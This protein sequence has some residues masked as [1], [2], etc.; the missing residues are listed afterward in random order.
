MIASE[1]GSIAA[2]VFR[3]DVPP[4]WREIPPIVLFKSGFF[5]RAQ[6]GVERLARD[7]SFDRAVVYAVWDDPAQ[8]YLSAGR[9]V[10]PGV[11]AAML[12]PSTLG[13]G[14]PWIPVQAA[15]QSSQVELET[16]IL[17]PWLDQVSCARFR[18]QIAVGKGKLT[19][20]TDPS[21]PVVADDGPLADT[22]AWLAAHPDDT[23]VGARVARTMLVDCGH[24]LQRYGLSLMH[25]PDGERRAAIE[26]ILTPLAPEVGA[27]LGALWEMWERP[28]AQRAATGPT[29]ATIEVA[30]VLSRNLQAD[31]PLQQASSMAVLVTWLAGLFGIRTERTGR[32]PARTLFA[33]ARALRRSGRHLDA[34]SHPDTPLPRFPLDRAEADAVVRELSRLP[35]EET[36]LERLLRALAIAESGWHIARPR[37]EHLRPFRIAHMFLRGWPNA[38]RSLVGRYDH[39]LT[40]WSFRGAELRAD[41]IDDGTLRGVFVTDAASITSLRAYARTVATPSKAGEFV[42]LGLQSTEHPALQAVGELRGLELA[43][44]VARYDDAATQS[45]VTWLRLQTA[46]AAGE[47]LVT[48]LEHLDDVPGFVLHPPIAPG[49][50]NAGPRSHFMYWRMFCRSIAWKR[51]DVYRDF[52]E[53]TLPQCESLPPKLQTE[54]FALIRRWVLQS[55]EHRAAGAAWA[56]ALR[57]TAERFVAASDRTW[58]DGEWIDALMAA[59]AAVDRDGFVAALEAMLADDRLDVSHFDRLID[60]PRAAGWRKEF[61]QSPVFGQLHSALRAA[62]GVDA[63]WGR[64]EW[65]RAAM[66][67]ARGAD[68]VRWLLDPRSYPRF[69]GSEEMAS[70]FADRG[71]AALRDP[72]G[73]VLELLRIAL[74]HIAPQHLD[75]LL[76]AYDARTLWPADQHLAELEEAGR[77]D[78]LAIR[79]RLATTGDTATHAGV[80]RRLADAAASGNDLRTA[81][82]AFAHFVETRRDPDA[83]DAL[84]S[85]VRA[86]FGRYKPARYAV[87]GLCVALDGWRV[88]ELGDAEPAAKLARVALK[89]V[90][91]VQDESLYAFLQYVAA[92]HA[93]GGVDGGVAH[94]AQT[95]ELGALRA[96]LDAAAALSSVDAAIAEASRGRSATNRRLKAIVGLGEAAPWIDAAVAAGV[97]AALEAGVDAT[98]I[99]SALAVVTK[100]TLAPIGPAPVSPTLA[101]EAPADDLA[102]ASDD[103]ELGDEVASDEAVDDAAELASDSSELAGDDHHTGDDREDGAST[104]LLVRRRERLGELVAASSARWSQLLRRCGAVG[105]ETRALIRRAARVGSARYGLRLEVYSLLGGTRDDI[106]GV[107]DPRRLL[108]SDFLDNAGIE[109]DPFDFATI[110]DALRRA[111]IEAGG[112]PNV[113]IDRNLVAVPLPKRLP[114]ADGHADADAEQDAELDANTQGAEAGEG[115][116]WQPVDVDD[117][118]TGDDASDAAA[119]GESGEGQEESASADTEQTDS[120]QVDAE[121]SD[122]EAPLTATDAK[123]EAAGADATASPGPRDRLRDAWSVDAPEELRAAAFGEAGVP[124]VLRHLLKR[125][126]ALSISF[127]V[128]NRRPAAL[129][130][131]RR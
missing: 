106:R 38:S 22:L 46:V 11:T 111:S 79:L 1:Q 16:G 56:P 86:A 31:G 64:V 62:T 21:S 82:L 12:V 39:I 131:W 77:L 80:V 89:W 94:L 24:G 19:V 36:D 58:L 127:G 115:A 116:G 50:A 29:E 101:A 108:G 75:L 55:D 6:G 76:R 18:P 65:T 68:A 95:G 97:A 33:V 118:G 121:T 23:S 70:W 112:A 119:G 78:A 27:L 88:A 81:A 126:Q 73:A 92:A 114:S 96:A 17:S 105:G 35:R 14:P 40:G 72:D 26:R 9:E 98:A 90:G 100:E 52:V 61:V 87:D 123:P 130:K 99:A 110:C 28:E 84:A 43:A 117:H 4:E 37:R 71:L 85:S 91:E 2:E 45:R 10:R 125:N 83:T 109:V 69:T 25:R 41:D 3:G 44:A 32:Q 60:G 128:V 102:V 104:A 30:R 8:V 49:V 74:R 107:V 63:I 124:V 48:R 57:A 67:R 93:A 113:L 120:E 54:L 59:L 66:E 15:V 53:A 42:A 47:F 7:A 103:A 122:A 129:L 13:E 51:A 34:L 5:A 20:G